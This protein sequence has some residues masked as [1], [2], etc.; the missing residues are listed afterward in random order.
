MQSLAGF[1]GLRVDIDAVK[2]DNEAK[3]GFRKYGF[4]VNEGD[5]ITKQ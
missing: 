1:M 3:Q 4:L 2:R 5:K